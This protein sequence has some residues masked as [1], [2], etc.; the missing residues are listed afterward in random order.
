M[1][2]CVA[3]LRGI[4][5]GRAKR[6]P[7]A[8]LRGIL[9]A[10]GFKDVRTLLNSGNAVFESPRPNRGKISHSIGAAI[11]AHCGFEVPVIVVTAQDLDDI[12]AEN[13]LAQIPAEPSKGLVAF[14]ADDAARSRARALLKQDWSPEALAVGSQAAYLWCPGGII[15]SKLVKAFARATGERATSR[16]WATVLKLQAEGKK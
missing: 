14:L 5:V 7:M 16:N 9:E 4:N 15:D 12:V 6:L 1:S 13:P 10:L 8:D 2:N 11:C 3:L